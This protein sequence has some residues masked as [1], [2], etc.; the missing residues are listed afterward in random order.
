MPSQNV[1]API[2]KH[3][4][5]DV[6]FSDI[7]KLEEKANITSQA[8]YWHL[9]NL[10]HPPLTPNTRTK[11]ATVFAAIEAGMEV[12]EIAII[13]QVYPSTL[14]PFVDKYF[15]KMPTEEED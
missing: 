3:L 11:L 5:T 2:R 4:M 1:Q 12:R 10:P 6:L 9:S 13:L 7:N 15:H 14:G 8:Y